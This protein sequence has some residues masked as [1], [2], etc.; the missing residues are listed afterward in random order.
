[1]SL[2]EMI[3]TL[4]DP[5]RK[6]GWKGIQAGPELEEQA[7]EWAFGIFARWDPDRQ[8]RHLLSVGVE[9]ASAIL[10]MAMESDKRSL[11]SLLH[12]EFRARVEAAIPLLAS[13]SGN[14]G[15]LDRGGF[16]QT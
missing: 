11:L 9:E 4:N 10:S 16:L 14:S 5:D 12:P 6:L 15:G 2:E 3:A 8:V 7:R 1:M 13:C